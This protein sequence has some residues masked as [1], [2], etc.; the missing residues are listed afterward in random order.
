[1]VAHFCHSCQKELQIL[2]RVGRS[3]SCPHCHADLHCCLNCTFYDPTVYNECSETQ[4]DRVLEKGRSNFCDYFSFGEGK[5]K[6]KVV[7]EKESA[8]KKLEELFKK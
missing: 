2:D 1:M 8:R 3:E 5:R 6:N 7:D 4:A